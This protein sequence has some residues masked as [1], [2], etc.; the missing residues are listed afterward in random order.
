MFLLPFLYPPWVFYDP[1]MHLRCR[2]HHI[3]PGVTQSNDT[4]DEDGEEDGQSDRTPVL[5]KNVQ[6][7]PR[8][9]LNRHH[10]VSNNIHRRRPSLHYLEEEEEKKTAGS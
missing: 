10:D 4:R 7:W 3:T 6:S 9:H 2:I 8:R 1:L 5:N